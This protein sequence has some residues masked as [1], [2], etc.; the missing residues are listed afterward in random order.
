MNGHYAIPRDNLTMLSPFFLKKVLKDYTF[1]TVYHLYRFSKITDYNA[2]SRKYYVDLTVSRDRSK[3]NE[4]F[5]TI[6]LGRSY[7]AILVL[8]GTESSSYVTTGT[9]TPNRNTSDISNEPSTEKIICSDGKHKLLQHFQCLPS[10][11]KHHIRR[12]ILNLVKPFQI[13]N[14]RNS[15][16][17]D[18]LHFL[19]LTVNNSCLYLQWYHGKEK[20]NATIWNYISS[21]NVPSSFGR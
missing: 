18:P 10:I 9:R 11:N 16:S 3:W 14:R 12:R 17:L 20:G 19:S 1:H 15:A 8:E 13:F 4:H 2:C 5:E 6:P 7:L 21:R